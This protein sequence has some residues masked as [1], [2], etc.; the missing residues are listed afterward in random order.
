MMVLLCMKAELLVGTCARNTHLNCTLGAATLVHY[1]S[2]QQ[3]WRWQ[4]LMPPLPGLLLRS[5]STGQYLYHH[6]VLC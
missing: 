6:Q 4:T 2:R 5:I 3:V 1:S